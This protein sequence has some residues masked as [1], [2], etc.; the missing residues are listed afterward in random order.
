MIISESRSLEGGAIA[1]MA[2]ADDINAILWSQST[3]Q[4]IVLTVKPVGLTATI[5]NIAID[6]STTVFDTL[7]NTH[8]WVGIKGFNFRHVINQ[9]A[10]PEPGKYAIEY[11]V[12]NTGGYTSIIKIDHEVVGVESN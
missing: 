10:F 1:V 11:T 9:S 8:G 3:V 5:N 7:Q 2:R 12:T 4:G 6:K